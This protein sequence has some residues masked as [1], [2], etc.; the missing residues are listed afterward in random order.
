LREWEKEGER[1]KGERKERLYRY[2]KRDGRVAFI[3]VSSSV[4]V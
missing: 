3:H 1:K 2:E 4:P